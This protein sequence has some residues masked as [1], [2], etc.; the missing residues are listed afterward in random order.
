MTTTIK[1]PKQ[2]KTCNPEITNGKAEQKAEKLIVFTEGGKGGVG[3]TTFATL[4][5]DYYKTQGIEPYVLDFDTE[6]KE[7]AG[8]SFFWRSAR[9]G[10]ID[11]RDGL[12]ALL[13]GLQS[14]SPVVFADMG[15]RSGAATF[16]WFDDVADAVHE[17]GVAFA[18]IGI[19]TDDPASV[20]SVIEWGRFLRDRVRHIIV[21]NK[22][23][24]PH[25]Q[26]SYWH[27]TPHAKAYRE[28]SL[29]A[30][31]TLESINP[32]LQHS[33]RVHG[34]TIGAVADKEAIA[35]ELHALKRLIRA[36]AIRRSINAQ[37]NRQLN[38][39]LP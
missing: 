16:A 13:N 36:Q 17:L 10:D 25:S 1:E 5:L 38:M 7:N 39:L 8:L 31:L 22:M 26:F 20:S 3:K 19:V 28:S 18:A 34:E 24:D 30:V 15:A 33:L 29:S 9:K 2:Q 21:L 6:S 14:E 4:L 32:D 27:E 23:S 37:F 35:P 11:T 12:D